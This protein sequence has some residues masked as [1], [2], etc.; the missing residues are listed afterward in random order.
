ML[1]KK[2]NTG[3]LVLIVLLLF[4]QGLSLVEVARVGRLDQRHMTEVFDDNAA[5]RRE[6]KKEALTQGVPLDSAAVRFPAL[7]SNV[8][9]PDADDQLQEM[10]RALTPGTIA[11]L[12]SIIIVL[13][14]WFMV[15]HYYVRPT[16]M[17]QR[18]LHDFLRHNIPFGVTTEGHDE[19][20][21]LRE[22]I[23]TLISMLKNRQ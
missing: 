19:V 21:R 9:R 4:S 15:N 14:F 18:R 16:L 7:E 20:A 10:W 17:I 23:E 3:F 13:I 6:L 8:H 11:L 1:S 12:V 22:N 5:L 2:I